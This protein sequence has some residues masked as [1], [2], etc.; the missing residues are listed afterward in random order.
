[1]VRP[2][3][4]VFGDGSVN[5]GG[6]SAVV[7]GTAEGLFAE[8]GGE[9][10]ARDKVATFELRSVV[11]ELQSRGELPPP[12]GEPVLFRIPA[13]GEKHKAV[14]IIGYLGFAR[15]TLRR[16]GFL[17]AAVVIPFQSFDLKRVSEAIEQAKSL[18]WFARR[19]LINDPAAHV[20]VRLE[21]NILPKSN[22]VP[23]SYT[24]HMSDDDF[25]VYG[26][27]CDAGLLS[28]ALMLIGDL[29]SEA[30]RMHVFLPDNANGRPIVN[31]ALVAELARQRDLE[32]V[33]DTGDKMREMEK[34]HLHRDA[35][36]AAENKK[37]KD[38][39]E[40]HIQNLN[41]LL[42]SSKV[43]YSRSQ[44]EGQTAAHETGFI[45]RISPNNPRFGPKKL[46]RRKNNRLMIAL[47]AILFFIVVVVILTVLSW[48]GLF[49]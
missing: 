8:E 46:R 47:G 12:E 43:D 3:S 22:A 27:S 30:D 4:N 26:G 6:A 31:A 45:N 11:R 18:Y 32:H 42:A 25:V 7:F 39:L 13:T 1:M 41:Q 24:A 33:N 37:E 40:A 21:G 14:E 20:I 9:F 29:R 15:D 16:E 49:Y 48:R 5:E 28:L 35:N 34:Q 44:A 10:R 38:N 2:A 23:E 17:A 19:S 36:M